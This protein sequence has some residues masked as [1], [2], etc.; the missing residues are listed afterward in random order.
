MKQIRQEQKRS[1]NERTDYKI[2]VWKAVGTQIN[3]I[4]NET[5]HKGAGC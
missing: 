2:H 1:I 5:K 4:L 3:Q